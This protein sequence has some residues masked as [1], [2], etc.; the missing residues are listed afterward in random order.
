MVKNR[1]I[2]SYFGFV[3]SDYNCGKSGRQ[4]RRNKRLGSHI[5]RGRQKQELRKEIDYIAVLEN[6]HLISLIS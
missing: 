5:I 1:Y 2:K 6:R 4:R 3:Y